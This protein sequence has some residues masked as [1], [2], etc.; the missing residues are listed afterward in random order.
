[1]NSEQLIAKLKQYPLAVGCALVILVMAV[2]TFLRGDRIVE[3]EKEA[4]ALQEKVDI[5]N[6]NR[7][8]AVNLQANLDQLQALADNIDS[9]VIDPEANTDNYRYFLSMS[10]KAQVNLV[11]PS[12]G[13]VTE[14]A[15]MKVYS[16]VQY[17]LSVSGQFENV[18]K[19]IYYL[20]TGDHI[21]R[22]DSMSLS[23][24]ERG[25]N[26]YV[27]QASLNISGIGKPMEK[28]KKK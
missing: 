7:E 12:T 5:I 11:D 1:M 6:R 14:G 16:L 19:F 27:V 8:N 15:G 28:K 18:L 10:E 17:P 9:R 21:V 26:K 20:R 4:Q 13:K 3:L 2:L 24:Q 23:P 25:G 22:I